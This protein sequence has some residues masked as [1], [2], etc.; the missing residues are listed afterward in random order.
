MRSVM[1]IKRVSIGH[2]SCTIMDL[3][4]KCNGSKIIL[5]QNKPYYTNDPDELLELANTRFIQIT[6]ELQEADLNKIFTAENLP[7][8]L[9]IFARN[10]NFA[11]LWKWS[12]GDEEYIR[13]I[14]KSMGYNVDLLTKSD[15][16]LGSEPED[17]IQKLEAKGYTVSKIEPVVPEEVTPA[18][19]IL[20]D[21]VPENIPARKLSDNKTDDK[22]TEEWLDQL[23]ANKPA[24]KTMDDEVDDLLGVDDIQPES[25]RYDT[26]LEDNDD[27][28]DDEE[29][30][31]CIDLDKLTSDNIKSLA[32]KHGISPKQSRSKLIKLLRKIEGYK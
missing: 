11:E 9:K 10:S 24:E 13:V 32:V 19:D 25:Q 3:E 26:D 31:E 14:L 20:T 29:K 15:S 5:L 8:I 12:P 21:A 6:P 1:G 2:S 28:K 27:S 16:I 22:A 30:D 4:L 17:L 18:A 23:A 7:H